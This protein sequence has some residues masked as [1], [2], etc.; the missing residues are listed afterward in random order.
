M[1]QIVI[2]ILVILANV[3]FGII[4]KRQ[5][6][7]EKKRREEAALRQTF[8]G[9]L[10]PT[11]DANSDG[12]SPRRSGAIDDLLDELLDGG[13]PRRQSPAVPPMRAPATPTRRPDMPTAARQVAPPPPRGSSTIPLRA[14]APMPARTSYRAAAR[15]PTPV[16]APS[17]V[18]PPRPSDR[19]RDTNVGSKAGEAES[20]FV[21]RRAERSAASE[22][23]AKK[24]A[25]QVEHAR[26][27]AE[28]NAGKLARQAMARARQ[29]R[30]VSARATRMRPSARSTAS[31]MVA[32]IRAVFAKP[33]SARTAFIAGEIISKPLGAR[34]TE[35]R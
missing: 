4:A 15:A 29:V 30:S 2:A 34:Q 33:E 31:P 11:I 1:N 8:G 5:R 9:A 16:R 25:R 7:A 3:A 22:M 23:E 17:A 18:Q 19:R 20:S 12:A 21:L 14:S 32:A 35:A 24:R 27:R 28:R 10:P 6:D 26:Q 13:T